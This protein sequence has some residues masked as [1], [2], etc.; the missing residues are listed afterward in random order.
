MTT[1]AAW[2]RAD[3]VEGFVRSAPNAD[4]LEYARRRR[5]PRSLTR[6]LDI[7]CGAGRNAL[8]L[9]VHGCDVIGIDR[10]P[11][12]LEAAATRAHTGRLKLLEGTMDALPIRSG[13]IDLIV[14]HG[15]WN[16]ARSGGEFRRAVREAARV[17]R[18][19]AALFVFT[20]SRQTLPS[21]ADPI[22]GEAFVF[23]QFSGA[24]QVFLTREEL[25]AELHAAG[26]GPDPEL[27]IR[28]LNLPPPGQVRIG[29]A[30]VIFQAGFRRTGD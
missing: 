29:G 23:T 22:A 1:A 2:D 8:P 16:L 17:A 20:F 13:T 12:M 7:G 9:A 19:G 26:F 3:V 15:I 27:P 25:V 28:E 18:P 14:A 6:V 21:E 30:P 11:A 10:S 4:L 5:C 24:P